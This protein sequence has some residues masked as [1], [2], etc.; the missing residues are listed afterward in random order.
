MQSAYQFVKEKRPAISPNLNFM[1]QLVE[2]E[3]ELELNP[4]EGAMSIDDCLPLPEQERLSER[5]RG[6]NSGSSSSAETT[7]EATKMQEAT[8][9]LPLPFVLKLPVPRGKKCKNKKLASPNL[10]MSTERDSS[11]MELQPPGRRHSKSSK[12]Y[13]SDTAERSPIL[14]DLEQE[15]KVESTIKTFEQLACKNRDALHSD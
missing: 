12:G 9:V 1:G 7:P 10:P 14:H 6:N 11:S 3:R 5:M 4:H 15:H 13:I 8:A 2:F